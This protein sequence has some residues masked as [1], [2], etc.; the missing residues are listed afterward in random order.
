VG[1]IIPTRAHPVDGGGPGPG[2]GPSDLG[3]A[4][5]FL[6][7]AGSVRVGEPARLIRALTITDMEVK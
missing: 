1:H 6:S 5:P 4:E 2:L 7:Q 3:W